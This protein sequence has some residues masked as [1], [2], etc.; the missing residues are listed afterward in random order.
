MKRSSRP[1]LGMAL[2]M[3]LPAMS[4]MAATPFA[5]PETIGPT[6]TWSAFLGGGGEDSAS[7]IAFDGSGNVYVTGRGFF[8]WGTPLRP[9]AGGYDVFVAKLDA[10]GVLL[11]NTFL[12]GASDDSAFGITVDVSG[13][14]YVAGRSAATWGA[15]LLQWAAPSFSSD[16]FVAKLDSNGALMWNAFFRESGGKDGYSFK[17]G[18]ITVD[19][20]GSVYVAGSGNVSW[21]VP[22]RSWSGTPATPNDALVVK[23][24]TNGTLLW[25]TFLGGA[26]D[27][28]G[29][30][31]ALDAAGNAYVT[32]RS[33]GGWGE[34]ILPWEGLDDAFAVKL[35]PDGALLWNTFLGG[36]ADDFGCGITVDGSANVY[37][38]GYGVGTWG[39][40]IRPW[41]GAQSSSDA[42]VV[43][44]D[45][46]GLLLWNTF[47]GGNAW[48]VGWDI[49]TDP[50]GNIYV[51]GLAY[52]ATWGVPI[53][54]W[55][56]N[57]GATSDAFM[58][59][60][61]S[62]GALKWNFFYEGAANNSGGAVYEI[63]IGG[64]AVDASGTVFFAGSRRDSGLGPPSSRDIDV[65]AAK[66]SNSPPTASIRY[67]ST[68]VDTAKLITLS[69]TDPD[70]DPITFGVA[71]FPTYGVLSGTAPNL[72]YLPAPGF[73]GSDSFTFTASDG[74]GHTV[75]ATVTISVHNVTVTNDFDGDRRSD[76]GAYF[77][78]GGNW[79]GFNSGNGFWQTQF[80]YAG[81]IPVTGDF[82]GDGRSDFGVYFPDTGSWSIFRSTE[83][84]WQ[85]Q[86][87][88]AGTIPVVGD[89]D[90][91]GRD[92]IGSYYPP[93]GNWYVFK[94]TEGFFETQF[95][96]AGTIP[97]VGDY[98]GDG[99][100]DIGCYYPPGGNWFVFKSSDG[101][102]QS[103]FGYAG[104]IPVV[105]DFDGDG[106]SDIGVY[107][108]PAGA[109]YIFKST[110]GFW[111]TAFGYAGTEPVVGDFDGDGR[112]D[113]G[114]YYPPGGNWYVFRSTAGFW[115]TQF[116]YE[117]TIPLGGTLR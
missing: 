102:S 111:Q 39:D 20:V 50:I 60:L 55:P 1:L 59:K 92:D 93:G 25:H 46:D 17:G 54:P 107:D 89:F 2:A 94:S 69:A 73:R 3:L 6:L 106:R 36:T 78:P 22:V 49:A 12:G 33:W 113:L 81:T 61:D 77:P 14:V 100:D 13:R 41:A 7:D 40:P 114:A 23:L 70:G 108:P 44:L 66:L 62:A 104:T 82:D 105:G 84:L 109:W 31:I 65:F 90:S 72:T 71:T 30:R 75:V 24:D 88:F 45:A 96:F 32:G 80:G 110:D 38:T 26:G 58:A 76:I 34:P 85:T 64:I 112:S 16:A 11:W 51:T 91:D 87:G 18:G 68:P 29:E 95:G 8:T 21:G 103:Q 97:V 10:N 37:V 47:L 74:L 56:G 57:E 53:H 116:G 117:G 86:F 4:A 42:F 43:K 28:F 83:G 101:F 27:D 115:E 35:G 52:A 99:R 63:A 98:D 15:P 67:Q 5:A 48:D 79:Y 19:A 9:P